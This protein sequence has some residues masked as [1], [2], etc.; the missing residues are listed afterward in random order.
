MKKK[1]L[2]YCGSANQTSQLFQVSQFLQDEYDCWFSPA[3]FDDW[4]N[5]VMRMGLLEMSIVGKRRVNQAI[6]YLEERNCQIDYRAKKN[7]YDMVYLCTDVIQ[8]D[9]FKKHKKI[10][11][12]EGFVLPE[13]WR[14]PIIK[15]MS[16]VYGWADTALTAQTD[17]YDYFCAAGE[18]YRQYFID[19]GAD[20][21][22]VLTTGIPNFDDLKHLKNNPLHEKDFVL[23]ITSAIREAAGRENRKKYLKYALDQADGRDLIFKLHPSENHDRAI[24]EIRRLTQEGVILME[25]NTEHMIANSAQVVARAS[26]VIMTALALDIPVCSPAYTTEE[27]EQFRPLQN[28]GRSAEAIAD[29]GKKLIEE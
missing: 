7:Q 2:F 5:L 25:G 27:L 15:R 19:R 14:A 20:P 9:A 3:Y 18:G 13:D 23:I 26:T 16:W 12:Q 8:P 4:Q 21:D 1:I 11:V 24:R 22:K 29:L 10:V 6:E 17:N 28:N